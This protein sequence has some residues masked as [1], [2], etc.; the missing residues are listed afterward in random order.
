M[1][2]TFKILVQH[3]ISAHCDKR[4][5]YFE[6]AANE[7]NEV[8]EFEMGL[9]KISMQAEIDYLKSEIAVLKSSKNN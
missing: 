1:S 5:S 7:I 4:P 9:K 8:H 3:I 2:A 6:S